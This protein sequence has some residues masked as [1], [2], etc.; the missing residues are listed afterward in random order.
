MVNVEKEIGKSYNGKADLQ[1][2]IKIVI[3]EIEPA[4][5]KDKYKNQSIEDQ[6]LLL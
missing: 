6:R 4:E 3:W 2:P 1:E 5:V